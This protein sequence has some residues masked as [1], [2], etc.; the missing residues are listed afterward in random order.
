MKS[1]CD[2]YD[3]SYLPWLEELLS[4]P[5]WLEAPLWPPCPPPELEL[6]DWLEE[7]DLLPP[8]LP[9]LKLLL[10]LWLWEELLLPPNPPEKLSLFELL[11]DLLLLTVPGPGFMG[12]WRR[13]ELVPG[14]LGTLSDSSL[15]SEVFSKDSSGVSSCWSRAVNRKFIN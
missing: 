8:P 2:F 3:Q 4:D 13:R 7:L 9:L 11:E 12:S 1:I 15:S 10:L 6:E 14:D 5:D